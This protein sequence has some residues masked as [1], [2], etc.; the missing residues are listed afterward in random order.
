LSLRGLIHKVFA[1]P[2]NWG[3]SIL[4]RRAEALHVAHV[5][6]L[7]GPFLY[8]LIPAKLLAGQLLFVLLTIVVG[9]IGTILLRA[10]KIRASG[11]WTL[12]AMWLIFTAGSL[13]EGGIH[14][15]SFAGDI[16]IVIFAGLSFGVSMLVATAIGTIVAG[17]LILYLQVHG[18]M[19]PQAFS[20]SDMNIMSDF[21][22]YIALTSIFASLALRRIEKSSRLAEKELA[23][24]RQSEERLRR[25]EQYYRS[26]I[27][28]MNE[29][30][31]VIDASGIIRYVS[32]SVEKVLGYR[33]IDRIGQNIFASIHP[34]DLPRAVA[35]HH[36]AL[37]GKL[38]HA[39]MEMR[40]RHAD[41][42]WRILDVSLRI[43]IDIEEALIAMLAARDVTERKNNEEIL[44]NSEER[45]RTL[46]TLLPDVIF[47]C[48]LKGN[49][50]FASGRAV[51]LFG[52]T[53]VEAMLGHPIADWLVTEQWERAENTFSSLAVSGGSRV[54]EFDI[55]RTDSVSFP[56]EFNIAVLHSSDG[57]PER[58]IIVVRD[59]SERRR[60]EL[61]RLAMERQFLQTQK[62]ESLGVLAGGIAHDFN[63][64]LVGI[65]GNISLV[66][67]RM[68]PSDRNYLYL[69]RAEHS[70]E[71]AA[72]LTRQMLAYSGR[73]RYVSEPIDLNDLIRE[74]TELFR[75]SIPRIISM[76]ISLAAGQVCMS[77]SPAQIQQVIMNLI[78]NA[79]EAIGDRTGEI[80]ILTGAINAEGIAPGEKKD[81][82][83]GRYIFLEVRD[84]GSGMTPDVKAHLFEPFFTTKFT[85]RGL[86]MAAVQGIVQAHK[87]RITVD[88]ETG[89]GSTIRIFFPETPCVEP[90]PRTGTHPAA[91]W[92]RTGVTGTV[93]IVDD[94]DDSRDLALEL[95]AEL[96]FT[97]R[98]A[99]HGR[100]ALEILQ[101]EGE[102]CVCILLDMTM[103]VMDGAET[104]R[105][106][107]KIS[108]TLPVILCSGFNEQD[109]LQKV[110][111]DGHSTFLQKPYRP[112]LLTDQILRLTGHKTDSGFP[113]PGLPGN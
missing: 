36:D 107:R 91:R 81:L 45:Y 54:C 105:E 9:L 16:T 89:S 75:S 13:T 34:D 25:S 47:L 20:Y 17:Y 19:P 84:N 64:L 108:R 14:S 22:V 2:G 78:T 43:S 69:Q 29:I 86:G 83:T 72:E 77:G 28:N 46:V 93:I 21:T 113:A 39:R 18:I 111:Q 95:V 59:I 104:F 76:D 33:T 8:I 15:S 79:F 55:L 35:F 110:V 73:G 88:S 67:G 57:M 85:G 11:L 103:P 12:I 102:A 101:Q 97:A 98:G 50:T 96:G 62:L 52:V 66:K 42:S 32:P 4:Q 65:L 106:I 40:Y 100:Q 71:R 38:E 56:A 5:I 31:A 1:V 90:R 10:G 53:S 41:G 61:E 68:N 3:D 48:D 92:K 63:N 74:N 30:I 26:I 51:D 49:L 82:P 6:M 60:L 112:T 37:S 44:R 7:F 27:D 24:R 94:E 87:G 109:V 70:G 99:V 23:E 80:T 58:L